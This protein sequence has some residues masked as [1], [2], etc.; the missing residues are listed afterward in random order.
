MQMFLLGRVKQTYSVFYAALLLHRYSLSC[1]TDDQ[2]QEGL[3]LCVLPTD[4]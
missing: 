1:I 4:T 2:R 3:D